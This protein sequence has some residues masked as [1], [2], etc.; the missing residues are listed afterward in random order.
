MI[1]TKQVKV[2]RNG[3]NIKKFEYL[4]Y[5]SN[6]EGYFNVK[7][8]DLSINSSVEILVQ[9]DLCKKKKFTKYSSYCKNISHG[10]WYSCS[11]KCSVNKTKSTNVEKYGSEWFTNSKY[12]SYDVEEKKSQYLKMLDYCEMKYGNKYW[13]KICTLEQEKERIKKFKLTM[14]NKR[15][16]KYPN[17]LNVKEGE[18]LFKCEKC[19]QNFTINRELL[20]NRELYNVEICTKCNPIGK[21][22]SNK[23]KQFSEKLNDYYQGRI[24]KNSRKIISPYELDI[25]LPDLKIA[26][27]FNGLYWHNMNNKDKLYHKTKSDLAKQKNIYLIHIWEDELDELDDIFDFVFNNKNRIDNIEELENYIII[28]GLVS[29]LTDIVSKFSKQNKNIIIDRDK[30]I[31]SDNRSH[32]LDPILI[33]ENIFNSGLVLIRNDSHTYI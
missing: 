33:K 31:I 32:F 17:L 3:S 18:F 8:E 21:Q 23:E 30:D 1:L 24:I 27:E 13:R 6:E 20:K 12:Y 11:K 15:F 5:H 19:K 9:C 16:E 4:G 10:N 14:N 28:K 7:V 26:F 22:F 2:K 25:Y 29:N